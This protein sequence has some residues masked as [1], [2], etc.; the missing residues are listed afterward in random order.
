MLI[1]PNCGSRYRD[2]GGNRHYLCARCRTP[3]VRLKGKKQ[4]ENEAVAGAIV[5][6][7]VGAALGGPVGALIGFFLGGILGVGGSRGGRG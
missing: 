5:G 1:C 2:P 7:A 3:L 6:G 4:K